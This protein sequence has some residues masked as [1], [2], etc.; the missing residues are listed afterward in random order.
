[1]STNKTLTLAEDGYTLRSR[2]VFGLEWHLNSL[3]LLACGECKR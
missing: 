2:F 3:D 1:M